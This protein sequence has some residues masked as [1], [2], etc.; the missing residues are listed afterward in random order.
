MIEN[1][2][3]NEERRLLVRMESGGKWDNLIY[4]LSIMCPSYV[5]MGF[6]IRFGSSAA[7]ITGM[8]IYAAFSL[9]VSIHQANSY[10]TMK[11]LASKLRQSTTDPQPTAAVSP[12]VGR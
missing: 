8:V 7:I 6:G 1:N 12:S 5:V 9:R 4:D 3:T 10:T 11:S 2:L